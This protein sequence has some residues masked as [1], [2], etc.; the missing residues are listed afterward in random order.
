[1]FISKHT[2]KKEKNPPSRVNCCNHTDIEAVGNMSV[3]DLT[4]VAIFQEKHHVPQF[5]LTNQAQIVIH[6]S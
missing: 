4:S 2:H 5:P 3:I 6:G 1:M